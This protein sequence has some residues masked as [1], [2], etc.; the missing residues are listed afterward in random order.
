MGWCTWCL[1]VRD[2]MENTG[3]WRRFRTPSPSSSDLRQPY[4]CYF[5]FLFLLLPPSPLPLLAPP[6]FFYVFVYSFPFHPPLCTSFLSGNIWRW[7]SMNGRKRL[8]LPLCDLTSATLV[9]SIFLSSSLSLLFSSL[10]DAS[11]REDAN[12]SRDESWSSVFRWSCKVIFK[13]CIQKF[14]IALFLLLRAIDLIL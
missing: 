10:R 7:R 14:L 1:R 12:R 9:F 2:A 13:R 6:L 5:F 11:S 4:F 8:F 3:E